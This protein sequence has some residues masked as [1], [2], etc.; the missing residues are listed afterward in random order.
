MTL[1][2]CPLSIFCS[3]GTPH[4]SLSTPPVTT[5]PPNGSKPSFARP[6][7]CTAG[8]WI[9]ASSGTNQGNKKSRFDSTKPLPTAGGRP[10]LL[11]PG[12][13]SSNK[14]TWPDATSHVFDSWCE[15]VL[16][17]SRLAPIHEP[18]ALVN[19]LSPET[20]P[21]CSP[22]TPP[23]GFGPSLLPEAHQPVLL[24]LK[25]LPTSSCSES[26]PLRRLWTQPSTSGTSPSHLRTPAAEPSLCLSLTHT[27]THTLSHTL[28]LSLTHTHTLSLSLA[29]GRPSLLPPARHAV[30]FEPL[31]R[32]LRPSQLPKPYTL[33]PQPS[34]LNPKPQTLQTLNPE[35]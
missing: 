25:P 21:N 1:V 26:L 3:H 20:P 30:L 10:S 2:R 29:G 4:L 11:H 31:L 32:S 33:N 7:L 24:V 35:P 8:R 34:T 6:L 16:G 17:N 9:P 13:S 19:N 28:C 22:E 23:A 14:R 27:H 15:R 18:H 12:Q 5:S